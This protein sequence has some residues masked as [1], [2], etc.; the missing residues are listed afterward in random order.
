MLAMELW[1]ESQKGDDA[2]YIKLREGIVYVTS[3]VSSISLIRYSV[4]HS[5]DRKCDCG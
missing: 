1:L 3:I 2:K 5:E 4:I